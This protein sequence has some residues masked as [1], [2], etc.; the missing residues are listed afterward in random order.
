[1]SF[2]QSIK[3]KRLGFPV[4]LMLFGM[5]SFLAMVWWYQSNGV[6][7]L[8][9]TIIGWMAVIR[10]DWLTWVFRAITLLGSMTFIVTA[11]LAITAVGI[12]KKYKGREILVFN[13]ANISGVLMMQILKLIFGRERPPRPWL[14]T[15]DG[16][17]FPSGHSLMTALFYG[18]L[19]FMIMR[20]PKVCSGRK[21]LSGVLVCLPVLVGLSR[22]YLGVHYAS[23]VLAGWA[24]GVAWVGIWMIVGN[25]WIKESEDGSRAQ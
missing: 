6:A 25:S 12:R 16:F 4:F 17:S 22:V 20:S 19:L 23:D 14:G 15:A 2:T 1:M 18:F 11:D 5:V 21:W 7:G 8:D 10:R 24:A 13:L 9:E 3:R